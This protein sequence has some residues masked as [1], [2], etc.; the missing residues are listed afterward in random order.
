M[1]DR[2][3]GSAGRLEGPGGTDKPT[4]GTSECMAGGVGGVVCPGLCWY[5]HL[6]YTGHGLAQ[7]TWFTF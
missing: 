6:G 1:V 3:S 7:Y 5:T 4:E 2:A